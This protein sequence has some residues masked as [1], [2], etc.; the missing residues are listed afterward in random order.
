[1][2]FHKPNTAVYPASRSRDRAFQSPPHP[3]PREAAPAPSAL[4]PSHDPETQLRRSVF[5]SLNFAYMEVHG[6]YLFVSG[7]FCSASCYCIGHSFSWWCRFPWSDYDLLTLMW[8]G[9]G[10]GQLCTALL[11]AFVHLFLGEY[12]D[13]WYMGVFLGVEMHVFGCR[14]YVLPH[15]FMKWLYHV[16]LFL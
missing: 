16:F 1:M 13:V 2:G 5:L 12:V 10:E 4:L 7:F 9:M 15:S 14:R 8:L 11:W 6:A 3:L